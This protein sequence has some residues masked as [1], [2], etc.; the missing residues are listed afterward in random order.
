ML[1]HTKVPDRDVQCKITD[2]PIYGQNLY[3]SSFFRT[4][5]LMIV[6][7]SSTVYINDGPELT[8]TYFTAMSNF[9]SNVC[10]PHR[11]YVLFR[12]V[13]YLNLATTIRYTG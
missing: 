6:K 3:K 4:R 10:I 1:K 9:V 8:L 5:S 2:M 13:G 12:H 7:L 11:L